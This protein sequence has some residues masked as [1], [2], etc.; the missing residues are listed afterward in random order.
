VEY[1]HPI[2]R[3]DMLAVLEGTKQCINVVLLD[4][5]MVDGILSRPGCV[6]NKSFVLSNHTHF[7]IILVKEE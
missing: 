4:A 2:R 6:T 3:G 5:I 1:V 7:G